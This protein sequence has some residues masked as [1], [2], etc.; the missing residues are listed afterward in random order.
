MLGNTYRV[1]P[2]F[3]KIQGLGTD[4]NNKGTALRGKCIYEH[5]EGRF[6]TLEFKFGREP[7]CK[8]IRESFRLEELI[9]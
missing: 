7:N 6:V 1:I 3:T 4:K 9:S 8:T 5:P 2:E